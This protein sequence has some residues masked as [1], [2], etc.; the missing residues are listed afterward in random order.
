MGVGCVVDFCPS[1]AGDAVVLHGFPRDE[2]QRTAWVDFVRA[3]GRLHWTP[4]KSSKICSLHFPPDLYNLNPAYL[5]EFGLSVKQSRLR[6]GAVPSIYPNSAAE[7]DLRVPKRSKRQV[8]A[9]SECTTASLL[10]NNC[11]N[12]A[13][14][15]A[16]ADVTT[17][18]SSESVPRKDEGTQVCIRVAMK[19][20]QAALKPRTKSFGT[21][22]DGER[23]EADMCVLM[24]ITLQAMPL[25]A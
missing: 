2:T 6:P 7:K 15:S 8:S 5:M 25:R 11:Y 23:K 3:T 19:S 12:L 20:T 17:A 24:V 21:Q 13:P 22:T 9:E 1:K 16:S 10:A 4:H 18:S 14:E